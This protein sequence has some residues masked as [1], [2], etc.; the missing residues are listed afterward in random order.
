ML[1]ID[2]HNQV[3]RQYFEGSTK[4]RMVPRDTPY[5]NRHVDQMLRFFP[6]KTNLRILEVGCG[7]GRYTLI[8]WRR[9][10]AVE[11]LDLSPILLKRL[12]DFDA[13]QHDY[14]LYCGDIADPPEELTER[15]DLVVGFDVNSEQQVRLG[16]TR[17]MR[18]IED[19]RPLWDRWHVAFFA[20]EKQAQAFAAQ[21]RALFD[22]MPPIRGDHRL[23]FSAGI[24]RS[25]IEADAALSEAKRDKVARYG[26]V[27]VAA[28]ARRGHGESFVR[29]A[30][31]PEPAHR[32]EGSSNGSTEVA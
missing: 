16:L 11:G 3:Q 28:G 21:A 20:A 31:T 19:L 9:G 7:M 10:L 24:G 26:E 5:L 1:R 8:L 17:V 32:R 22:A 6:E 29:A 2:E 30:T 13:G 18:E 23:S 4:P 14:P 15:Y 25:P 27:R 12:R